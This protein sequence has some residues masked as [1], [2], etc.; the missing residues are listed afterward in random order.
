MNNFNLICTTSRNLEQEATI[1]INS[2]LTKLG[3]SAIIKKAEPSGIIVAKT[4]KDPKII[5]Q[6]LR[7]IIKDEPWKIRY[8]KRV[9]P[10]EFTVKDI[11][12][13]LIQIESYKIRIKENETF[14]ITVKKRFSPISTKE[15]IVEIAKLIKRQV[16]LDNPE[17]IIQIE[18][19][20]SM[21]GASIIRPEHILNVIKEKR[22]F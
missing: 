11:N 9:I 10:I 15:L 1:E 12:Q 19:I 14:R 2:I 16:N 6:E 21:I 18:I 17:W 3:E 5:I 8:L 13:L 22:G 7:N 20:N 4:N